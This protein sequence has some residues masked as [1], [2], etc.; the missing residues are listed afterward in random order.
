LKPILSVFN[1]PDKKRAKQLS[2]LGATIL[3]KENKPLRVNLVFVDD[4]EIRRLNRTYRKID[5][6]TDVLSFEIDE[7]NGELYISIPTAKRNAK[8]YGVSYEREVERLLTHGLLHLCGYDHV[9]LVDRVNMRK[10]EEG[11]YAA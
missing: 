1:L 3:K 4:K 11:Y 5:R 2:G 6:A 8:R 9:K 7:K 10:K